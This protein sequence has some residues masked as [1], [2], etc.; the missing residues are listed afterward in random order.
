LGSVDI[1]Q[2][3]VQ[4]LDTLRQ[5]RRQALPLLGGD[6]QGHGIQ[7]P[8]PMHTLG[9]AVD[10]VCYAVFTDQSPGLLPA[11]GQFLHPQAVQHLHDTLPVRTRHPWRGKGLLVGSCRAVIPLEQ[12]LAP[13]RR[14][15][16]RER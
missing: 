9:I 15:D 8:R 4:D 6:H 13:Q 7:L 14:L 12:T 10:V 11:P 1:S 2:Q 5:R 16:V 3:R